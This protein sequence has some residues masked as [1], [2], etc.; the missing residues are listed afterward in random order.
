M[1]KNYTT[2]VFLFFLVFMTKIFA[3]NPTQT[4]RG[5]VSDKQ[6]FSPIPGVNVIIIG[7]NPVKVGSTDIDGKF[8]IMEVNPG[9]YDLKVTY[10]GYKEIVLPNVVVTSGKEIV[11]EI[12]MEENINSLNEIEVSGTKKNETNNDMTSVSGRS[13]SM[14]EV[15]RYAGGRSDPARLA[16][17]FAGVNSPDDS[18]NDIVIRGNSPVGVLWRIDGMN[19]TNPNHF[20]VSIPQTPY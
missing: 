7:S 8:K 19:V 5:T 16:A 11:L 3:Q 9:R 13:F 2:L 17:N 6:S 10:L 4:I 12:G 18:R 15:N 1:K 14:E 20:A